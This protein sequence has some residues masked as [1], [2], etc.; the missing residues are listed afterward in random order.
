MSEGGTRQG[1]EM[2][3][4][5]LGDMLMDDLPGMTTE[6]A[7]ATLREARTRMKYHDLAEKMGLV[8]AASDSREDVILAMIEK[9]WDQNT[10]SFP[11]VDIRSRYVSV[12]EAKESLGIKGREAHEYL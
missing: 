4:D 11:V 12:E 9:V 6:E 7:E 8:F 2:T 3:I 1:S 5:D 10:P